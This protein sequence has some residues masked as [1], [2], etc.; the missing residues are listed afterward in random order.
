MHLLVYVFTFL[1]N[2]VYLLCLLTFAKMGLWRVKIEESLTIA[3]INI[4]TI[5]T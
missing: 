5:L 1:P 2:E 3:N 4:C